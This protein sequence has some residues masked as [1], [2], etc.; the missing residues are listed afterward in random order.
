MGE[1]HLI[2]EDYGA[3][4][5]EVEHFGPDGLMPLEIARYAPEIAGAFGIPLF[6]T[7]QLRAAVNA[8]ALA[9]F[10]PGHAIFV[11]RSAIR[12]WSKPCRTPTNPPASSSPR[13]AGSGRSA[14]ASKGGSLSAEHDM[15]ERIAQRLKA[16]SRATSPSKRGGERR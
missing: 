16:S 5:A 11:T 3:R 4:Q 15:A 14:T 10:R 9:A 13:S 2:V 6:S 7:G 12:E 1:Y 8:G